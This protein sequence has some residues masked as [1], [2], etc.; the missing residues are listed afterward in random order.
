MS[1]VLS[2]VALPS[3]S[4]VALLFPAVSTACLFSLVLSFEHL[5]RG[6]RHVPPV[7]LL[8]GPHSVK[9]NAR[10]VSMGLRCLF[11]PLTHTASLPNGIPSFFQVWK[12]WQD[13]MIAPW[14]LNLHNTKSCFN[15]TQSAGKVCGVETVAIAP[16]HVIGF[17]YPPHPPS[18]VAIIQPGASRSLDIRLLD[19]NFGG[20]EWHY[21]YYWGCMSKHR[22]PSCMFHGLP[23]LTIRKEDNGPAVQLQRNRITSGRLASEPPS[24][25]RLLTLRAIYNR[26][27]PFSNCSLLAPFNAFAAARQLL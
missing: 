14:D 9:H 12:S 3:A 19:N 1:L 6:P 23:G 7:S 16:C 2:C 10:C 26:A 18:M 15:S 17:L 8:P 21:S 4:F 25:L 24:L 22:S 13:P 20:G 27:V 5:I 11:L